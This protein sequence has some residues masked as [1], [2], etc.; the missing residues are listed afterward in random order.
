MRL[1]VALSQWHGGRSGLRYRQP[2][3]LRE[4]QLD[5]QLAFSTRIEWVQGF[6]AVVGENRYHRH[7]LPA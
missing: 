2:L 7:S 1:T 6:I 4:N 5:E 3:A